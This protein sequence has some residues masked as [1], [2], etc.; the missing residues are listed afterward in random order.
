MAPSLGSCFPFVFEIAF[1]SEFPQRFRDPLGCDVQGTTML[2]GG[3]VSSAGRRG[4][5]EQ[6][7]LSHQRGSSMSHL[8]SVLLGCSDLALGLGIH[9]AARFD[10]TP[11][12]GH[13]LLLGD[14]VVGGGP[15]PAV[16]PSPA[17]HPLQSPS[18]EVPVS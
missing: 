5:E 18:Q 2:G 4:Q 17:P 9:K 16:P 10:L 7:L 11:E 14:G 3:C 8:W 12:R 15:S 6:G 1:H 13:H